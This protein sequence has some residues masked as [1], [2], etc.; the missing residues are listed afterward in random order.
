MLLASVLTFDVTLNI[1][2]RLICLT[3]F[4]YLTSDM[5]GCL[6]VHLKSPL[7]SNSGAPFE[8]VGC[9]IVKM[10]ERRKYLQYSFS[11]SKAI[12]SRSLRR[13]KVRVLD[14][15]GEAR[16]LQS[17]E[18]VVSNSVPPF[19]DVQEENANTDSSSLDSLEGN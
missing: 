10:S 1:S 17:P 7:I 14:N 3:V 6:N 16:D 15:E 11:P 13:Y 8:T 5:I 4:F 12:P 18:V 9:Q 19:Q 2:L